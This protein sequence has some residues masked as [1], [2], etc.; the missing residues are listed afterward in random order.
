M[1]VWSF[2]TLTQG[3][4]EHQPAMY[5]ACQRWFKAAG[6]PSKLKQVLARDYPALK[7]ISI[8]YAL[9]ERA[10]NVVVAD[11]AFSWDDLGSWTALARHLKADAEGN[12][13][14]ADFVH[15]DG[16]RN[17]IFDARTRARRALIAV[18]GLRDAIVVQTD[19][20]T[21]VA[22][23]GQAQKVKELVRKLA[24]DP[25]LKKLV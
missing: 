16:A 1:F 20:A 8:D 13:A 5:E 17:I 18:V 12:C 2:V 6:S 7:K 23:K 3:L 9:M 14:V 24:E 19:D 25:K 10:R 4:R 22:D 21:L 11:G 15:V